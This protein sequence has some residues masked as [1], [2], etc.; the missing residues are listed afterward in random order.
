MVLISKPKRQ[1]TIH[2]KRRTGEHHKKNQHYLKPYWPYVPMLLIVALGLAFSSFWGNAQ[3]SVLGYATNTTV[4]GLFASTNNQRVSNGL[5]SLAINGQLNQAAQAK[6]N[7]M[8]A[9][10]YWSHNTPDGNSPWV[11]ITNAGYN[12]QTAGENLAYGF[13]DSDATITA[14][15]NSAEHRANILNSSYKD[16]G[17]GI[18]NS[19]N[20]Q[21]A[22]PETIVV[23]MYGSQQEAPAPAPTAVSPAT[24]EQSTPTQT[25]TT[26]TT[27]T[28]EQSTPATAQSTTTEPAKQEAQKQPANTKEANTT[29]IAGATKPTTTKSVSRIQLLT[30]GQAPWSVF[31]ISVMATVAIAILFFRHGIFWHRVLFRGETFVM[32]HK[33]LDIALVTVGV[34]GFVLTRTTGIIH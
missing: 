31:A 23:A 19:E 5:G 4:S 30:A 1:E 8:V 15:M 25:N 33:M 6:A 28:S 16:V 9:R 22:G 29:T 10:D 12:Y 18:A 3:K 11:F 21:G 24:T 17:F 7:D 20:Y 13:S 34:L 32:H 2:T 27:P 26:P 14:W